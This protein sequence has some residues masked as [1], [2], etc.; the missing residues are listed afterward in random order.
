MMMTNSH[1]DDHENRYRPE[2]E[3]ATTTFKVGLK[4]AIE[5]KQPAIFFSRQVGEC[6]HKARAHAGGACGAQDTHTLTAPLP[7]P[8][9]WS[10]AIAAAR[11]TS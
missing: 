8:P 10:A 9:P 7:P 2:T 6:V 5:D 11:T 3:K 1:V 4:D